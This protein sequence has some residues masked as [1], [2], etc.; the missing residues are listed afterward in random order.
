MPIQVRM[1]NLP[2]HFWHYKV[3]IAIGNTLGKYL[4]IDGDKLIKR[5]FTFSRICVEVDLSQGLP[6]S[7]TRNFNNTQWLQPTDAYK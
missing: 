3:S 4:K 5:I 7:I 6:E 2:I 1:H